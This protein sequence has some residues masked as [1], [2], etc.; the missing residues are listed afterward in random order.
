VSLSV[1]ILDPRVDPEPADYAVFRRAAGLFVPWD[2]RLTGIESWSARNPLVLALVRVDGVLCAAFSAMICRQGRDRPA[3]G[4]VGGPARWAPRWVEVTQP[5]LSGVPGWVFAEHLDPTAQRDV[6]RAFER[7]ACRYVGP[8][9]LG[10][11]YQSVRPDRMAQVNGFGRYAR[12]GIPDSAMDN[13]FGSTQDWLA[14]LGRKRRSQLRGQLRRIAED[15]DLVTEA[16]PARTDLDGD[17]LASLL[18]RHRE[19]RGRFHFD[20]RSPASGPYLTALIASPEVH[21]LTH[22]DR[23]GR[24][25]AFFTGL[26]GPRS[27][28]GQHWAI[29]DRDDGGRPDLY[30][31]IYQHA[32]ELMIAGGYPALSMG[33]GLPELKERLGFA[34]RPISLVAVPRLVAG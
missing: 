22:R 28:I 20:G 34:P 1:D 24:L 5:W 23:S 7:A 18:H 17:E 4:A 27:L 15:N 14:T 9:C 30:F 25:L 29:R 26:L 8:G 32:I 12:A 13:T 19:R 3:P 6:V 11:I 33:R 10:L 2:Y 31:G 21:T 16:A